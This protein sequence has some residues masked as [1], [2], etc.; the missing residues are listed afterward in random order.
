MFFK[1]KFINEVLKLNRV[2]PIHL[3]KYL[4][5]YIKYALKFKLNH[6]LLRDEKIIAEHYL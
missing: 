5:H 6:F 1:F 4:K 3:N 2:E